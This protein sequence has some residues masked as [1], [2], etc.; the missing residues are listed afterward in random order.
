[1]RKL[2][3]I[4]VLMLFA[5][6]QAMA[7]MQISGKVTNAETGEPIPGVS[8]FLKS[9]STVGTT[10]DMDGNYSLEVPSSGKTLVYTFVGMQQKE[11]TIDG[12]STINVSLKPSV[13]E[14][15][16]VVVTAFGVTR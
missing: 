5:G 11:V 3:F 2:S 4:I 8:I 6:F 9:Q 10:T 1:M 16:E 7:Q 15:E 13:Q 14:M 12:R